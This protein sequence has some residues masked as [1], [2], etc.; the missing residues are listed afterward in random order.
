MLMNSW[1][2]HLRLV[3]VPVYVGI[4]LGKM[5]DNTI[6]SVG[7]AK[8]SSNEYDKYNDLEVFYQ[9]KVPLGRK[10]SGMMKS[11]KVSTDAQHLVN[12]NYECQSDATPDHENHSRR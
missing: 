12:H 2:N 7:I 1:E 11:S 6:I 3:N 5:R 10:L 8:P 4:D 9:E